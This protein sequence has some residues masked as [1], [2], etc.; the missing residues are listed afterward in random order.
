MPLLFDL[1]QTALTR[2]MLISFLSGNNAVYS[3][4]SCYDA[5]ENPILTVTRQIWLEAVLP[6]SFKYRVKLPRLSVFN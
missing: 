4:M 3:V 1:G 2:N 6:L 5:T